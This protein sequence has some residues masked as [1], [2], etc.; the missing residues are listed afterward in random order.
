M[1][2]EL[3]YEN[4]LWGQDYD[5]MAV[6]EVGSVGFF[7]T[8]GVG[9]VP[10]ICLDNEELFEGAF[11]IIT[12]EKKKCDSEQLSG[13]DASVYTWGEV[14]RRGIFAFDWDATVSKY[15]AV[16]VPLEPIAVGSLN[17][18][19]QEDAKRICLPCNFKERTGMEDTICYPQGETGDGNRPRVAASLLGYLKRLL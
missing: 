17:E 16:C 19:L 2:T 4:D 9:P 7:V 5:W 18:K 12:Q 8:A 10:Q 1:Q 14:A 11:E 3:V 15:V 13:F 6:D